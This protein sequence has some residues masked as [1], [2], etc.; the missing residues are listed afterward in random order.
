[1]SITRSRNVGASQN[2][3]SILIMDNLDKE[4]KKDVSDE[5]QKKANR[6]ILILIAIMMV[7]TAAPLLSFYFFRSG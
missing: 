5:T 2:N 7:G 6:T 1:M 3:S 4:P